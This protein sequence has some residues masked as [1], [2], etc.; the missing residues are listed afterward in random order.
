MAYM[1][2]PR[3]SQSV[4]L[5]LVSIMISWQTICYQRV[6]DSFPSDT[7]SLLS[8]GEVTELLLDETSPLARNFSEGLALL[9]TQSVTQTEEFE[10]QIENYIY[11]VIGFVQKLPG[12]NKFEELA[13]LVDWTCKSMLD[14]DC[15]RLEKK[16]KV[17]I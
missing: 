11:R 12:H 9:T 14:M 5:L 3:S 8:Y 4:K 15:H 16:K 6:T 7:T 2:C 10:G 1:L 17:K 13:I